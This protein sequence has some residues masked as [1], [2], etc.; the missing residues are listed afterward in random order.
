MTRTGELTQPVAASLSR[1]LLLW[2]LLGLVFV[3][4]LDPADQILHLKV[5]FFIAVMLIWLCRR[6]I[7]GRTVSLPVWTLTIAVAV[8]LPVAFTAIGILNFTVHSGDAPLALL[9]SF[10]FLLLM[11]VLVSE[12]IDLVSLLI[13]MSLV[14]ALVTIAMAVIDRLS[15]VLFV[16]LYNFTIAKKNADIT[17]WRDSFGLGIG[18]FYYKTSPLMIFPLAYYGSH[19]FQSRPGRLR[20]LGMTLLF[21]AAL[22]VSG[23]RANVLAGLFVLASMTLA[24]VRR[25]VGWHGAIALAALGILA[26]SATIV[27]KAFDKQEYSNG[28]KLG[29]IRSYAEEFSEK[30]PTL[31]WGEGANSGFYSEGFQDWATTTELTYLE[32]VRQFGIPV[33][34][35]LGAGLVW[36]GYLLAAKGEWPLL[37]AYVAY[38]AI[39]ASN[40]LLLSS[41]GLLAICASWNEAMHPADNQS[42]FSL[43]GLSV[44]ANDLPHSSSTPRM[45]SSA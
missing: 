30:A 34:V 22:L 12:D 37:L 8:V 42:A 25:T 17:V 19:V 23:A 40:P 32:M 33:A 21:S 15:P 41:T 5:P 26:A 20:S 2:A 39:S 43:P 36:I 3:S 31:L 14:V 16:G 24:Q 29:H 10:L 7:T 44:L 35:L 1:R 27:P 4:L 6:G 13:R 18:M 11:P 38:L 45:A 9:K 28:V